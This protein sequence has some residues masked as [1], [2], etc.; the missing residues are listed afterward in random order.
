VE[1][2]AQG[3]LIGNQPSQAPLSYLG[4]VNWVFMTH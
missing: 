2:D 1:K 4:Q 3:K